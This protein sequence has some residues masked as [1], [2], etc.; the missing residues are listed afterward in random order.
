[1]SS[2]LSAQ[3]KAT[4]AAPRVSFIC[5]QAEQSEYLPPRNFQLSDYNILA[6]CPVRAASPLLDTL[7]VTAGNLHLFL[8]T[9]ANSYL[10]TSNLE[11]KHLSELENGGS[12]F[13]QA[14]QEMLRQWEGVLG[15]RGWGRLGQL[16]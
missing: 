11:S 3:S 8:M 1:M 15:V 6:S 14:M 7:Q 5:K 10:K 2:K 9:F 4:L 12:V 16:R 13:K